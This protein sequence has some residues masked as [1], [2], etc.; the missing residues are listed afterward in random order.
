MTERDNV[1]VI[2][3]VR[4][5]CRSR[6]KCRRLRVA[7]CCR[8]ENPP[9]TLK[10]RILTTQLLPRTKSLQ[11][12]E[13]RPMKRCFRRHSDVPLTSLSAQN[14]EEL[15]DDRSSR[16]HRAAL[17]KSPGGKQFSPTASSPSPSCFICSRHVYRRPA[18]TKSIHRNAAAHRVIS[19][20]SG[21]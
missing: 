19:L 1:N 17:H 11:T 10:T 18:N 13:I 6:R 3:A 15:R 14:V 16:K 20:V 21:R 2:V 12:P 5:R 9:C 8:I 7:G 4:V